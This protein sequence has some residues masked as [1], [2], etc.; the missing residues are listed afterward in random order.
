MDG[1]NYELQLRIDG[2][3]IGNVR[4]L[5]QNLTWVRRRTKV[6]VDEIDFTLN[7]VKFAEWCEDRGVTISQMLHP[8]ALDC[9]VVRNL[10]LIH[11]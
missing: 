3:L 1:A 4:D 5:A 8:L 7:D 11:I 9:R 2:T 10:S 6:G